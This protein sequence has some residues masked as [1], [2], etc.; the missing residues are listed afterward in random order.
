MDTVHKLPDNRLSRS[1]LLQRHLSSFLKT[2][3][4]YEELMSPDFMEQPTNNEQTRQTSTPNLELR[5]Q[6]SLNANICLFLYY[7]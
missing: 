3:N 5:L 2:N 4:S 7:Y 6:L 1:D